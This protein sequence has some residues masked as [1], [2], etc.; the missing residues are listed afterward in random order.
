MSDQVIDADMARAIQ[1]DAA[2][3]YVLV[4]DT[5]AEVQG[6]LPPGLN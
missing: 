6:K 4:A 5:L 1:A 3:Q 2:R